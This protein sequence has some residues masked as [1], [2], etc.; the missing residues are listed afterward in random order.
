MIRPIAKPS[1]QKTS[2]IQRQRARKRAYKAGNWAERWVA[3]ILRLQGY[4]I[5]ARKWKA[6]G[7]EIDIIARRGQNLAII[8]VKYRR[9]K[10]Q[11]AYPS[12]GQQQRILRAALMWHS[13]YGKSSDQLRFDVVM[14]YRYHWPVH[15]KNLWCH[16]GQGRNFMGW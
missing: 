14:V 11:P 15:K 7:A 2:Q 6:C 8:E 9:R 1:G 13:Q 16:E 5:L 3:G 10:D 12:P 4:R